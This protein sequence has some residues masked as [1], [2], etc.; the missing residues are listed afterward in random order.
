MRL[1]SLLYGQPHARRSSGLLV[2]L[3]PIA[4]CQ[5]PHHAR[6]CQGSHD[7]RA[8]HAIDPPRLPALP[9]SSLH[10][11]IRARRWR[12]GRGGLSLMVRVITDTVSS[13]I[14]ESSL[15]PRRHRSRRSGGS[16]TRRTWTSTRPRCDGRERER[17][18]VGPDGR[19]E[20]ER[21]REQV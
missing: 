14:P 2:F 12:E 10:P 11:R 21:E 1:L 17:K 13:L 18:V 9:R 15:I 8:C 20:R 6:A 7:A 5:G 3:F 4:R 19:T 16:S